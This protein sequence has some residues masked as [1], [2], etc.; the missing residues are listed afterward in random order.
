MGEPAAKLGSVLVVGGAGFVGYHVTKCFR[1]QAD[2]SSLAVLSRHPYQNT[3][4]GVSYHTGDLLCPRELRRAITDIR[5]EI[6]IHAACLPS[7]TGRIKAHHDNIV[8]GTRTLLDI[9]RTILSVKVFIYTSSTTIAAGSAHVNLDETAPSIELDDTWVHPY[10]RCKA[11]ADKMVLDANN[12]TPTAKVPKTLLTACLRLPLVYGERDLLSI[13]GCLKALE[14]N[15]TGVI[16]GNGLNEWDFLSVENAAD[17]HLLL[18]IALYD[19]CTHGIDDSR[20]KID[21]QAFNVTDGVRQKFWDYPHLVWEGAGWQ[22]PAEYRPLKLPPGLLFVIA[23]VFELLYWVFTLGQQMPTTFT[24]QEI[25]FACF[26]HTYQ[27]EK[28]RRRLNYQPRADFKQG[29]R[30]AV[31][32]SMDEQGWAARLEKPKSGLKKQA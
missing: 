5:P 16:F 10:E 3:L 30:R 19:R 12:P 18:A 26:E 11:I 23:S 9:A 8:G 14:R 2:C 27:I 15:Q 13:P 20:P 28:A 24:R 22:R 32:W 6:I 4:P 1:E 7:T 25:A 17:A 21:G 29:V 31:R